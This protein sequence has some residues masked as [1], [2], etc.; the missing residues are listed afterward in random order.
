[1]QTVVEQLS[2][3]ERQLE[4]LTKAVNSVE[5]NLSAQEASQNRAFHITALTVLNGK[6]MSLIDDK[7]GIV[8]LNLEG[9]EQSLAKERRRGLHTRCSALHDRVQQLIT[10]HR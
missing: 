10:Q 1:M 5:N 9:L 4:I 6:V 8:T 7:D 2:K 3:V